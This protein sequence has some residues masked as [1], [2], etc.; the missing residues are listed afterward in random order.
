M[1]R[2]N[3]RKSKWH[4]EISDYFGLDVALLEKAV[5]PQ[6]LKPSQQTEQ[7]HQARRK[8]VEKFMSQESQ[9]IYEKIL[10]SKPQEIDDAQRSRSWQEYIF[11]CLTGERR[12]F[13]RIDLYNQIIDCIVN[14]LVMYKKKLVVLDYGCGSS[15]FTRMISEDYQEAATTISADVC[16][17]AVE[18]SMERNRLY[19]PYAQGIL[20]EDVMSVPRLKDVDLILAQAVFEH[21]PNSTHQIQGLI[22]ALSP[23]GILIE[24]YSGHSQVMPHKSDTFSAYALRD[25]NLD[26]MAEQLELFYGMMPPKKDGI[27]ERDRGTRYWIKKGYDG[28]ILVQIQRSLSQRN[29]LVSRFLKKAKKISTRFMIT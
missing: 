21:L 15:L 20:I 26:M 5:P 24:N 2:R 18:F 9:D 10:H 3:I 25:K 22:D 17:F 11:V 1:T 7:F 29:S 12:S 13:Q 23:G 28:K 6:R 16:R 19:N 4:Q 27:Y 8:I 14:P